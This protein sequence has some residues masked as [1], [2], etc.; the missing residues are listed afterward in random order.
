MRKINSLGVAAAILALAST[1][2]TSVA[3]AEDVAVTGGTAFTKGGSG[4]VENAT[5]LMSDGV[6]VSVTAGGDVPSGYRTV[7]AKGKW[8]TVGF[9]ASGSTL[10]LGEVGSWADNNDSRTGAKYKDTIGLDVAYSFNPRNTVIANTRIEGVTRAVTQFSG[11]SDNWRGSGAVIQLAGSDVADMIVHNKGFIR[12]SVDEGAARGNGGSRS[13]MWADIYKKLDAAKPKDED[14]D[15]KSEDKS[16][17]KDGEKA[18]SKDDKKA[19]KKKPKKKSEGDKM[20]DALFAGTVTLQVSVHRASDIQQV[21]AMQKKYG[22]K[23]MLT[24]AREAWMVADELAAAG[25]AVL[26]NPLDN[27]PSRFDML[28]STGQ[29]AERLQAA[30]VKIAFLPPDTYQTRLVVQNAGN[31]VAMGLSWEAAIDALTINPAEIFGVSDHYG[32][33]AAGMTADIV[34]W[35]G[36]PLEVMTSPDAVFIGGEQIELVSRQTLLRDRYKEIPRAPGFKK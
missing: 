23:V 13:A 12:L 29:N 4:K 36:D 14:E 9:M 5:I 35:D 32:T 2:L 33:M 26:L 16:E 30:G 1:S 3:L 6:I 21:I 27:L 11:T 18:D 34:V 24:G 28:A 19:D 8:V 31:A 7:D 20:L 25:I 15:D 10:G 17:G 22:F